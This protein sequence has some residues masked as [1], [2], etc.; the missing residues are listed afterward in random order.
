MTKL[1]KVFV[2]KILI[3]S[4]YALYAT[5]GYAQRNTA[6]TSTIKALPHDSTK[7]VLHVPDDISLIPANVLSNHSLNKANMKANRM[8]LKQ[9]ADTTI[10]VL[11]DTADSFAF[12]YKGNIISGFGYR[13]RHHHT[14]LDI[15][16]K[17]GDPVVSAFNGTVSMAK[18]YYGYGNMVVVTNEN[19]I[20]TYYA[21]LS[22]IKVKPNQF[23]K[24]GD[25]IGLGGRTGRATTDHLHFE[26]RYL[27]EPFNPLTI[28]DFKLYNLKQDTLKITK[29]LFH[30]FDPEKMPASKKKKKKGKKDKLEQPE[31][32][33]VKN[34][35]IESK[36]I[37]TVTKSTKK[38]PG[39]RSKL[40][41][42]RSGDTLSKIA[43]NN[44]VSLEKLMQANGLN[45][46]SI[47]KLGQKIKIP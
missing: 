13:G 15:K 22:K 26:T 24:A 12:P 40:Y 16:L 21:H 34:D 19:G 9:K 25:L 41:K 10:L 23:V 4:V 33:I 36:P 46:T 28:L 5:I 8:G 42:V 1:K 11:V 18:R 32:V 30:D 45:K 3:C 39:E 6:D 37:A 44:G 29:D 20:E 47:L 43:R 27:G 35:S 14:G 2:L 7:N 17:R 31:P 38:T